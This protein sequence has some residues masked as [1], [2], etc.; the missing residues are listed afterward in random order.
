[1]PKKIICKV[2]LKKNVISKNV[3]DREIALCRALSDENEGSCGWGKCKSCGVIPLLVKL[4]QG[5]L[6]EKPEEIKSMRKKHLSC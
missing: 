5:Q 2:G 3:F 6:I 4:H 1:M